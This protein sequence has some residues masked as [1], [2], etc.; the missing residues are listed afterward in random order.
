[1]LMLVATPGIAAHSLISTQQNQMTSNEPLIP[2]PLPVKK[3][4]QIPLPWQYWEEFP[5]EGVLDVIVLPN[6]V[7]T[8][9]IVRAFA[10]LQY[11]IPL[12][13]L[14][15]D[16]AMGM[17]M[18]QIDDP[19]EPYILEPGYQVEYFIPTTPYHKAVIM[20]YSIALA[21]TPALII[22]HFVN[23]IIIDTWNSL[24]N[25]DLHNDYTKPINNFELELYGNIV[26]TD[27]VSWYDDTLGLDPTLTNSS[28]GPCWYNGWG[29]PPRINNQ[30]Y[31]I[32][33]IW[34]DKTRP[35]KPCQWIHFGVTLKHD[36]DIMSARGYW[37]ISTDKDI[38]SDYKTTYNSLIL[39][40]FEQ[41]QK[42]FPILHK[43]LNRFG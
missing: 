22:G 15:W 19:L 34:K 1:M 14:T 21:E 31:G 13:D 32:E 25:F 12:E 41:H 37:T 38:K 29:V 2:E 42:L 35:V 6:N 40:F 20:R 9:A 43:I 26:S 3:V 16:N 7:S 11:E 4:K 28:F 30:S 18:L 39:Q 36:V 23:E 8:V 24:S 27:V 10:V 5:Q 33:M 17:D